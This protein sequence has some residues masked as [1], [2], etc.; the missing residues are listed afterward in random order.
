MRSDDLGDLLGRP[1]VDLLNAGDQGV[2]AGLV[3]SGERV[4]G[5][6]A[7]CEHEVGDLI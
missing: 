6:F 7:R 5:Y 3:A 2:G 1:R 4:N